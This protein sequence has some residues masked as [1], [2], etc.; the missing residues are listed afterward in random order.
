M[1]VNFNSSTLVLVFK[2]LWHISS[3]H[4]LLDINN[5]FTIWKGGKLSRPKL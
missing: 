4:F 2:L 3:C 1:E 5:S